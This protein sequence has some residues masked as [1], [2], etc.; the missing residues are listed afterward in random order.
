MMK[1]VSIQRKRLRRSFAAI[2]GPGCDGAGG[3]GNGESAG[4][5]DQLRR[6]PRELAEVRRLLAGSGW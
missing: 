2:R 3:A 6:P 5:A 1:H 4:G